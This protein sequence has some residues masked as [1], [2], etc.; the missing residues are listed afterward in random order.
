MHKKKATAILIAGTLTGILFCACGETAQTP[1][2]SGEPNTHFDEVFHE[3][4]M[5]YLD[6]PKEETEQT[7]EESE[8]LV[9]DTEEP[10][11]EYLFEIDYLDADNGYMEEVAVGEKCLID[12]NCDGTPE[13]VYYDADRSDTAEFGT[14]VT[15]FT[16]NGGDFKYTLYLSDQGIHIQDPDLVS[17][18]IMDVDTRDKYREVAILD[19]GANGIPY[20]YFIRYTGV[21]TYCLGYV[22]YFP[23]DEYFK[24]IGNGN[25][26][27]AYDLHLLQTWKAPVTYTS[28][29]DQLISSNFH[30]YIPE[31]YYPYED[32][33]V[34]PITQL[35]DLTLYETKDEKGTKVSAPAGDATI[36]FTKTDDAHWIYMERSDGINGW[37]YM[38]NFEVIVSD[39][40][41]YNR[42]DVFKNLY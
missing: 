9:D 15:A 29:S 2:L 36:R 1:A 10:E 32:Q 13:V 12:L 21:G 41:E 16:I 11:E 14:D 40:K 34:E 26:E 39:G 20:T 19:H 3:E 42:R 7:G 6:G 24:V 33:N 35:R 8:A 5:D 38:K 31:F 22:P 23:D 4:T 25:V 28:G 37:F 18:Y 17:Y 27:T 30:K